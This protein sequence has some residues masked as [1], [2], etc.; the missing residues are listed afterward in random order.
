[1]DS[2]SDKSWGSI[3]SRQFETFSKMASATDK[4]YRDKLNRLN[5]GWE[6]VATMRQAVLAAQKRAVERDAQSGLNDDRRKQQQQQQQQQRQDN[7]VRRYFTPS[8]ISELTTILSE[9]ANNHSFVC[10]GLAEAAQQFVPP[11]HR[12]FGFWDYFAINLFKCE[13]VADSYTKWHIA[14]RT[15]PPTTTTPIKH[16]KQDNH[17]KHDRKDVVPL[18]VATMA[19]AVETAVVETAEAVATAAEGALPL[20]PRVR[21]GKAAATAT[22]TATPAA[23]AAAAA[24]A[25]VEDVPVEVLAS[26]VDEDESL[27]KVVERWV[28]ADSG[29]LSHVRHNMGFPLAKPQMRCGTIPSDQLS[30]VDQLFELVHRTPWTSSSIPAKYH[31]FNPSIMQH[32]SDPN[33]FLVNLRAGNYIMNEDHTYTGHNNQIKTQNYIGS[34]DHDF[35]GSDFGDTKQLK[36]PPMPHPYPHI[37]GMEDLRLLW[38]PQSRKVYASF[39]S[40]EM[41]PEHKPQVCLVQIDVRRGRVLGNHVRLHGYQSELPQKNWM[42]FAHDGRLFF[43]YSFQP[44]T[45]LQANPKTGEV[46]VVSVDACPVVNDWRGSSTL[47]D[48]PDSVAT[49]LPMSLQSVDLEAEKRLGI[50]RFMALVHVSRFP[51]YH[52]QI[53]MM[54]LTP[55]P[56]SDFRPFTMTVTHQ[57]PPF[58]FESHNVEFSCGAAFTP[59]YQ[60]VVIPYS[61]RDQNCTA[62]RITTPSIIKR[63]AP[64]PEL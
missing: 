39:T 49:Q 53:I 46:R 35:M 5:S 8:E 14:S 23:A 1:M 29:N 48:L 11:D 30:K 15:I 64:V 19:A 24:A 7:S 9:N 6:M 43:I 57:T 32:P 26:A 34:I 36:A 45:V 28:K 33:K 47:V 31:A 51:R 54:K 42:G 62:I 50:R 17:D 12:G 10:V 25:A 27:G 55:T 38:E 21:P 56:H 40:L 37:E 2:V 20:R 58:V 16:D 4:E 18:A 44:L 41:T 61:K 3:E 60:Q 13:R 59:D 52:H 63:L 22:A